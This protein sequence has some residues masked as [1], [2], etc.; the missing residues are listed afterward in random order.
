VLKAAQ[1]IIPHVTVFGDDY[2]TTD[3]TCVRDYIHVADLAEAHALALDPV[4]RRTQSTW[5][6][7]TDIQYSK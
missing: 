3:G 4:T 5:E 1:G 7:A 6:T 2:P